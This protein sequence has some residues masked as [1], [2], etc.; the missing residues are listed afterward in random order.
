MKKNQQSVTSHFHS[1]RLLPISVFA[2]KQH[3]YLYLKKTRGGGYSLLGGVVHKVNALL[4]VSLEPG[5]TR[6]QQLLLLLSDVAKC[7]DSL[8]GTVGL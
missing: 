2:A 7:V 4:D 3:Q 5:D 6:L 8:L 1:V